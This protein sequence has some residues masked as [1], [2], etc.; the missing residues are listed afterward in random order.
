MTPGGTDCFP[1]KD[2]LRRVTNSGKISFLALFLQQY[3]AKLGVNAGLYNVG[4]GR[5]G[6]GVSEEELWGRRRKIKGRG[7]TRCGLTLQ[8]FI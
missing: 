2:N 3:V 5:E 1:G 4:L 8:S 6:A 7:R